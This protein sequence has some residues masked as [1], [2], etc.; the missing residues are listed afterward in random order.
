MRSTIHT[1]ALRMNLQSEITD[2][3]AVLLASTLHIT[4]NNGFQ[5][6][7]LSLIAKNVDVASGTIC[8]H[9]E[10]KNVAILEHYKAIR[11]ERT[12]A[13]LDNIKKGNNFKC[14]FSK[15]WRNGYLSF[16]HHP[17]Q[18][19]F[20]EQYDCSP[21]DIVGTKS[22]KEILFNTPGGF[23]QYAIDKG[24]LKKIEY[25]LVALVAFE[26]IMAKVEYYIT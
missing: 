25:N 6:I 2:Q 23:F 5:G 10:D 3:K 13:M 22:S 7:L 8:N 24:F 11:E 20:I 9:L 12:G 1:F 14:G 26:S 16:I 18:L 17:E 19:P 4:G 21:Y 15:A